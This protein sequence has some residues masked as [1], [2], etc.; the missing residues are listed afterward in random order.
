MERTLIALGSITAT[1]M[2]VF[3]A[4]VLTG[5][6]P[7]EELVPGHRAWVLSFPLVDAWVGLWAARMT[8][9]LRAR[10]IVE[11][12]QAALVSGSGL[13]LLGVHELTYGF[14]TGLAIH[15]SGGEIVELAVQVYCLVAGSIAMRW[16]LAESDARAVSP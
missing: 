13:V 3:W 5:A 12:R 10:R 16:A 8:I 15:P 1:F 4:A 9:A 14:Y 2:V 6:S 11:A 7:V